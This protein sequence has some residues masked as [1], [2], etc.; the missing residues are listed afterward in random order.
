MPT[1][2]LAVRLSRL[3]GFIRMHCSP[4]T[5]FAYCRKSRPGLGHIGI[6]GFCQKIGESASE[7]EKEPRDQ[8]LIHEDQK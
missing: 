3:V 6:H 8:P 4:G 7:E 2:F 1:A 5:L